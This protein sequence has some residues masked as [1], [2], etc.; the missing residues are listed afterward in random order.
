M[1]YVL[2]LSYDGTDFCGWQKQPEKRT[3]QG[4]LEEAA[5]EIFHETVKITASG[6]TD[7][8]VHARGQ[9]AELCGNTNIPAKKLAFCLNRLLPKD[10]KVRASALA[11]EGFDVTRGA[12][13]KTYIYSAY[14]SEVALPLEARYAARLQKRPNLSKMR[15]AAELLLGEHDFAAFRSSGFTSKTSVRTLYEVAVSER[16]LRDCVRYEIAFCGNGFLYNMARIA[17]GELFAVGCGKEAGILSAFSEKKRSALAKTMPP[18]GLCLERVEYSAPL[19]EG[20]E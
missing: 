11:P 1:K 13:K 3:V 2:L 16:V 20:G 4:V 10:V 19:F 9:I 6:R 8:G 14:F 15:E 17:A 12:K 5:G 7:A 18:E